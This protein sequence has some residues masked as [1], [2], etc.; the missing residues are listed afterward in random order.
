MITKRGRVYYSD[1]EVHGRRVR[2]SLKT[3]NEA[4]ARAKSQ[5]L[6]DKMVAHG[7]AAIDGDVVTI[8]Y[9]LDF[10]W[11]HKWKNQRDARK[12]NLI[13][14][15]KSLIGE[16]TPLERIDRALLREAIRTLKKRGLRDSTINR[17]INCIIGAMRVYYDE[18]DIEKDL[19]RITRLTEEKNRT[20]YLSKREIAAIYEA[21]SDPRMRLFWRF[22]IE[23]GTRYGDAEPLQWEDFDWDMSMVM[24]G[25]RK[26]GA[27]PR[28]VPIEADLLLE[29]WELRQ[30]GYPKPFDV[31]YA[32][33]RGAL[34]RIL[35]KAGIDTG[36]VTLHTLR[37][38]CATWLLADG[39]NLLE[40]KE[41][42]GHGSTSTTE[43]YT[44]IVPENLR[45]LRGH[46]PGQR[47][48]LPSSSC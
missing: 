29:F 8:G 45:R 40:V 16:H 46:K 43:R 7:S 28:N 37:H 35:Q 12:S 42:L 47:V 32:R 48:E 30:K 44:Q 22:L 9:V 25:N 11:E 10:A 33:A 39:A 20:R 1:F 34:Q 38:T 41:W 17:Y 24:V 21:E 6:Y 26:T 3:A 36:D 19:P 5:A 31:T 23:V 13:A 4:E 27:T 2:R 14:N 15:C 18:N